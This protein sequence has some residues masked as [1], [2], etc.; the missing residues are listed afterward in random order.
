MA[1]QWD[2]VPKGTLSKCLQILTGNQRRLGDVQ[3]DVATAVDLLGPPSPA[4]DVFAYGHR[5]GQ[6]NITCLIGCGIMT[7][8]HNK[9]YNIVANTNI[10][11]LETEKLG[12]QCSLKKSKMQMLAC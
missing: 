6:K 4:Y 2:D 5:T 9:N 8:R 7:Q 10:P 1:A 11:H 12:F 3:C